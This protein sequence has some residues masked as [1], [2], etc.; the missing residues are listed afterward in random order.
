MKVKAT[1]RGQYKGIIKERGDVFEI[2]QETAD[3]IKRPTPLG[4]H[5][6][7]EVSEEEKPAPQPVAPKVLEESQVTKAAH[8]P[9]KGGR[10]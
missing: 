10:K 7:E 1:T 5:W 6:M 3:E 2:D 8:E 4:K 9:L